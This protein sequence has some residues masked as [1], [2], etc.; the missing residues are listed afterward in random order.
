MT[1]G[2]ESSL[3]LLSE[4]WVGWEEG[5]QGSLEGCC[6]RHGRGDAD[7]SGMLAGEVNE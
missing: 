3:W 2:F 6:S 4:E 5:L 7:L 1:C